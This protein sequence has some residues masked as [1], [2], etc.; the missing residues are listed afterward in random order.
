M[1]NVN[2]ILEDVRQIYSDMEKLKVSDCMLV[3]VKKL[4]WDTSEYRVE[5]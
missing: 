5:A 4:A 3:S 2:Q 1:R